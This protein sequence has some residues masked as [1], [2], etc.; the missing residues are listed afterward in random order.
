MKTKKAILLLAAVLAVA[1]LASGCSLLEESPSAFTAATL[2]G[3]SFTQKDLQDKDL[4]VVNL[5]ATYCGPCIAEMPDLAAFEKALPDNVRLVTVC[6]DA[7]GNEEA[8][9][10]LLEK[11]GYEGITLVSGDEGFYAMFS[12]VQAVP[13]TVFLDAGGNRVGDPIVG[14]GL[15]DFSGA[16]LAAVNKA[17]KASGKG[18]IQLEK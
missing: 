6:M 7:Q 14:G 1:L 15:A 16:Y 13:T 4:T 11:A 2:E 8:A 9:K 12:D 17:L 10:A 3:G 5:W 18:E